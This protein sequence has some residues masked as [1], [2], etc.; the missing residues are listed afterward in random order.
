M[1]CWDAQVRQV[2]HSMLYNKIDLLTDI[3]CK[4]CRLVESEHREIP[5]FAKEWW[6]EHKKDDEIRIEK[7]KEKQI[8]NILK[9]QA[10]AKLT[11]EEMEALGL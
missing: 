10:L 1:V 7:E 8:K 3:L 11:K 9:D 2:T 5:E 4:F 6:N